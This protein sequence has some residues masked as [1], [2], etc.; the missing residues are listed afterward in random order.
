MRHGRQFSQIIR[1]QDQLQQDP[2]SKTTLLTKYQNFGKYL[3]PP[4]PHTLSD[5]SDSF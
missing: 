4:V 5:T 1:N 2:Q 3:Y